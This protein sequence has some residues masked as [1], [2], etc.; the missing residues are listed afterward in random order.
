MILFLLEG[1]HAK[2]MQ[3]HKSVT[4]FPTQGQKAFFTY[5]VNISSIAILSQC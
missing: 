3:E 2:N 5:Y 4:Y 1:K